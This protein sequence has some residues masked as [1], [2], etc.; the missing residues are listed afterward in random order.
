MYWIHLHAL[1]CKLSIIFMISKVYTA[2]SYNSFSSS[3]TGYTWTPLYNNDV[4]MIYSN[5]YIAGSFNL[6]MHLLGLILV[7]NHLPPFRLKQHL[8]NKSILL[9]ITKHI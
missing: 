8:L 6:Q 7:S 1:N 4:H 3:I 9:A 2:V 5:I